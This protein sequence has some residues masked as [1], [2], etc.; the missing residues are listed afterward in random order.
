MRVGDKTS[1]E[2]FVPLPEQ[3]RT[4]GDKTYFVRVEVWDSQADTTTKATVEG[5]RLRMD[6]EDTE[7]FVVNNGESRPK[8]T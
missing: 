4:G 8:G 2:I 5:V 3:G 6:S 1:T 7:K